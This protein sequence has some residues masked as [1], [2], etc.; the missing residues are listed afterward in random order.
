VWTEPALADLESIADH[1]GLDK[2]LAA[3]LLVQKVFEATDRLQ[4]FPHLG[5]IPSEIKDL[6]YRQLVIAPCR[7]F[8]RVH[9]AKVFVVAVI[10]GER[11]LDRNLL[12]R[13]S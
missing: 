9:T 8:Y 7:I 13:Q 2:P 11:K 6:P 12:N 5:S 1:I 10:R 3:G 4:R